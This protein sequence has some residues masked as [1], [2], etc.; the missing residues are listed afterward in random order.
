MAVVTEKFRG[1]DYPDDYKRAVVHWE[2][3][4]GEDNE[5]FTYL[6]NLLLLG[7]FDSNQEKEAKELAKKAKSL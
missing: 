6:N 1:H 7:P 3:V 2:H 4:P 5:L